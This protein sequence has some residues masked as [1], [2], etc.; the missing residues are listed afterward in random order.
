MRD[1]EIGFWVAA[2]IVF[3]RLRHL[4]S[5]LFS[6]VPQVCES[7]NSVKSRQEFVQLDLTTNRDCCVPKAPYP[8]AKGWLP[9]YN[10]AKCVEKSRQSHLVNS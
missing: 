2:H 7:G 1:D 8:S 4:E 3:S 9:N 5:R 6:N 10:I